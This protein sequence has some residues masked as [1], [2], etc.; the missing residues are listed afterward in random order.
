MSGALIEV[1]IGPR[2][3]VR[4]LAE[5][6]AD[7]E[8][9]VLRALERLH[10]ARPRQASIPRAHIAAELPDLG[11]EALISGIVDRLRRK[12]KLLSSPAP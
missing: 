10:A 11:S 9:R 3:S 2:R 7:L 1:P 4:I 6:V 8:D 5:F 12:G